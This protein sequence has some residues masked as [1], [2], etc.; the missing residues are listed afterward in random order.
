M[1]LNILV[2][3]VNY[4]IDRHFFLSFTDHT[5]LLNSANFQLI[6]LWFSTVHGGINCSTN[7]PNQTV[8][9]LK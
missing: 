2:A 5:Q 3:W 6:A 8:A 7:E 9:P 1:A 4:D